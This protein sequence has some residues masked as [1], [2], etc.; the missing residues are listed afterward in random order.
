M[1]NPLEA[2]LS[3]MKSNDQYALAK[4]RAILICRDAYY[5]NRWDEF[6]VI[7]AE[8]E[9][10]FPLLNPETGSASRSFVEAGKI[11]VMLRRKSTD[12]LVVLEF[13]TTADAV[14]SSSD[15]W[16]RLRMDTQVSKYFLAAAQTGE[17][18][19]AV[20]YDV[21]R[22]PGQRPSQIALR[23]ENGVKIVLDKL[24][25][26]V[27]TK[28]GAKPRET[29][30]TEQGYVLQTRD[31]T[32]DEYE[33]RLISTMSEAP[34][35]YFAQREAPRMDSDILEYMSDAWSLSQQILYFR[36]NKIWPRNP[37]SC[38]T[39]GRCEFFD[40]CCGRASVD[41]IH[42]AKQA[43]RHAELKIQSSGD[44]QLLT[45]SRAMSL[46]KCARDH[47]L[48]YEQNIRVVR[49]EDPEALHLG[50][51]VHLGLEQYFLAIMANQQQTK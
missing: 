22:K 26:R 35:D 5:A 14:D 21:M 7:A 2:A 33:A 49:S 24:G 4:A 44:K 34:G 37:S 32:P 16:D 41:G 29:G 48:R 38:K 42:F 51:L 50:S 3:A 9:F 17:S 15:Y 36:A 45:N 10:S 20:L 23:D 28:N 6:N 43:N 19:G 25:F 12:Q 40:L 47:D 18:V 13:K 1:I 11:D 27:M 46:R 8:T 39:M 31:E 30:D